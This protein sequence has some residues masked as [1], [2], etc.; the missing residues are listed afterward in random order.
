MGREWNFDTIHQTH[1]RVPTKIPPRHE[2]I[3]PGG[4]PANQLSKDELDRAYVHALNKTGVAGVR[5]LELAIRQKIDQRTSGGPMVLRKAFK[6]FDADASGDI[7]PDE[8]YAA[9][10]AFG[11]EFTEDQVLA[12]FG[13]YDV[14]RDGAL[15]YYEFIDKVLDSG[16][17]LEGE[18]SEPVMV[19]VGPQ[20][21]DSKTVEMRTAIRQE[22][23]DEEAC[24]EVFTRFD[25]NKSGEIDVR[26]L[27]Q[28]TR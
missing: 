27:Q 9:M 5:R 19:Q 15:S 1:Y 11:L 26:E 18:K 17:G 14:D 10:H 25:I 22:D 20:E 23:I 3:M 24:R 8:F 6:Y 28:L 4:V 21:N 12:L 13:Y 16:F 2:S 7:D